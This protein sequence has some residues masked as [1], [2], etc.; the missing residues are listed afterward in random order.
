MSVRQRTVSKEDA[1]RVDLLVAQLG[2]AIFAR[3]ERAEAELLAMGPKVIG[4]LRK[5]AT[6]TD[7]EQARRAELLLKQIVHNE[8]TEKLPTAAPRLLAVRKPAGVTECCW[9]IWPSPRTTR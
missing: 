7:M 3:R 1:A 5:A 6:S 9:V 4:L 2:D 8:E